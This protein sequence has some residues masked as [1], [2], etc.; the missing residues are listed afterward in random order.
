MAIIDRVKYD[1]PGNI[2]VWRYPPDDLSWGTQV[3]VNQSQEAIF[4]K[5]GQAL[6]VMGPGTHTLRADAVDAGGKVVSRIELPFLR[7]TAETV[8]AAQVATAATQ[9]SI[10]TEVSTTTVAPDPI[11][12]PAK[13]ERV[14]F[15]RVRLF[16][17]VRSSLR[18]AASIPRTPCS[19]SR[20]SG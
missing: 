16:R 2:L 18:L 3:I 6:D 10:W 7:E 13:T 20:R 12:M 4:F 5:G 17:R 1:G 8:A 19:S 11:W 15:R 14:V 9:P